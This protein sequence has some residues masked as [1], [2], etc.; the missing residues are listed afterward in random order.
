[1]VLAN[2]PFNRTRGAVSEKV[3]FAAFFMTEYTETW[4]Q[5]YLMKVFNAEEVAFNKFLYDFKSSFFDHNC[6]HH[7]EPTCRSS[8]HTLSRMDTPLIILYQHG[9]KENVQLAMVMSYIQFTSLR[10]VQPIALKAGQEIKGIWNGQPAPITPASTSAPTTNPNAMELLAVQCVPHNQ[11]TDA[12]QARRV[13]LNLCFHFGQAG[14]V[15]CGCSN[16]SR[17]L[18]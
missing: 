7:A 13:Q 9:L 18:Q 12:E 17:K 16:G 5:P 4:S 11:L 1:M 3:P 15:S 14:N 10:T 8:T 2:Q 6:Q